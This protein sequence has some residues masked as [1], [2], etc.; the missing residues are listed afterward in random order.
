MRLRGEGCGSEG[1]LLLRVLWAPDEPAP[2]LVEEETA[3]LQKERLSGI[4]HG[5]F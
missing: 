5:S 4:L 3:R 2:H 1:G